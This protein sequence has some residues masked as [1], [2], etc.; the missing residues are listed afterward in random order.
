M[1]VYNGA[2]NWNSRA[3]NQFLHHDVTI[4]PLSHQEK[5]PSPIMWGDILNWHLIDH[6]RSLRENAVSWLREVIGS[7]FW[8]Q[9][10]RKRRI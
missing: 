1:R 3:A 8:A 6:N 9:K 5:S 7:L 10:N 4:G 2:R